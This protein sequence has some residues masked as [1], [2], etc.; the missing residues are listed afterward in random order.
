MREPLVVLLSATLALS[1]VPS[2]RGTVCPQFPKEKSTGDI[3]PSY[4]SASTGLQL[5]VSYRSRPSGA[6]FWMKFCVTAPGKNICRAPAATVTVG[7]E[8]T[9]YWPGLTTK[10]ERSTSSYRLVTPGTEPL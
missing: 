9:K 7:V 8:S 6:P 1:A 5:A 3:A 10:P 2:T 4:D